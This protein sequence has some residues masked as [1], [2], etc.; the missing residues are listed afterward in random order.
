MT[1]TNPRAQGPELEAFAGIEAN[2]L[3]TQS[4]LEKIK[5][6]NPELVFYWGNRVAGDGLRYTMLLSAGF[7]P[8]K[9]EDCKLPPPAT[10]LRDGKIMY[11]DLICMKMSKV[12]YYGALKHNH[13]NAVA[14]GNRN[15]AQKA[16]RQSAQDDVGRIVPN[17]VARKI[18]F[19]VPSDQEVNAAVEGTPEKGGSNG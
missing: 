10:M 15:R 2:P 11:G 16:S 12:K 6:K 13:N 19:F 8:T 3:I 7:E 1:M 18:K 17:E 9:A 4:L 5:P 14:L